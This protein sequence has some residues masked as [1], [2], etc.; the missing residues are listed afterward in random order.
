M[1]PNLK[2]VLYFKTLKRKLKFQ[3]KDFTGSAKPQATSRGTGVG[4]GCALLN[5][6]F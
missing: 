6:K 5:F 4:M 2:S 3:L 1:Y